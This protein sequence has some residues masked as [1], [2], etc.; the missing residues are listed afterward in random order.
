MDWGGKHVRSIQK[1]A[2]R[3]IRYWFLLRACRGHTYEWQY[4]YSCTHINALLIMGLRI[5]FTTPCRHI[6]MLY[7]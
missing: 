5:D 6:I 4:A 1:Q 3:S 2:R 7:D